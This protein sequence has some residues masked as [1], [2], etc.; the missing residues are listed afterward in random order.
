MNLPWK[1][2]GIV[3][4]APLTDQIDDVIEFID[5][6]LAPNGC[7]LIVM[8]VRCRYQFRRH[9][10]C[11]GY[12][13]LSFDDVKKLLA[14]CRKNNIKL[15]PKMNLHGHQSGLHNTPT[16]GILHGHNEPIP[17]F[18]DGILRAYPEFDEQPNEKGVFYSRSLCMTNPLVKMLVFDLMDELLDVFESDIIH[19]GCDEVFHLGLCEECSKYTKAELLSNWINTLNDHLKER[20]ASMMMWGDRLLNKNE[21]TCYNRYESADNGTHSAI[22]TISKD[23]YICD[24][25]YWNSEK[26]PSV[27]LF[28][29]A[30]F[31]MYVSPWR[32]KHNTEKFINYAIEHDCGNIEGLLF[33]TWCGSGE[34]AR[35]ILHGETP[36]WEHTAEIADTLKFVFENE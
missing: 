7:N 1:T 32:T 17:D 35:C 29:K 25:H 6:Y 33:T 22:E 11:Q 30:G 16:D 10:E 31:K 18:R 23:V 27:E 28:A 26:F 15:V 19:V 2:K 12:D 24:W 14:V 36:K 5:K 4:T 21:L 20:G 3:L 13:P 34:L 9:P 8:Q